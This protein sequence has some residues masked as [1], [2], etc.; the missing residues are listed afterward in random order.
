VA[1]PIDPTP[2]QLEAFSNADRDAPICMLNLLKF[3]DKA[4]Y[5]DGRDAGG[6]SG[7]EAYNLYGAV[8]ARKIGEVGGKI[9]WGAPIDM[10]VIGDARDDW[11]MTVVVYYPSRQAFLTMVEQPDYQAASVH[12][13][14]GL[15]RT[16]IIQCKG[17]PAFGKA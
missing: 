6:I 4:V 5:D 3:R 12:R 15:A 1:E 13:H 14:A 8:A 11:D 10:T 7:M 9:L 2:A 17:N 16:A